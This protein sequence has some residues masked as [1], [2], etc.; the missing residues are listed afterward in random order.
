MN[1]PQNYFGWGV[2]CVHASKFFTCVLILPETELASFP[3]LPVSSFDCL[4]CAKMECKLSKTGSEEGL[5]TW[6][7]QNCAWCFEVKPYQMCYFCMMGCY[8]LLGEWHYSPIVS[9][10][11]N[12]VLG[13]ILGWWWWG[14]RGGHCSMVAVSQYQMNLLYLRWQM[15]WTWFKVIYRE[16]R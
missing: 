11:V 10:V 5:G 4:Q 9:W 16:E 8:S 1:Q 12:N 7:K 15:L 2:L 13:Y 6:L 14:E 3:G